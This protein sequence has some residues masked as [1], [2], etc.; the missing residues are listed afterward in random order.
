[1]GCA[2]E[3]EGAVTDFERN[4]AGGVTFSRVTVPRRAS[5]E[6]FARDGECLI[7]NA[8]RDEASAL[9]QTAAEIWALCDGVLSIGAIA[10]ALS[11]RYGVDEG[12]LVDEVAQALLTLRT[13]GLVEFPGDPAPDQP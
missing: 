7:Y 9:N 5:V 6:D 11:E 13:R 12:L 2:S 10:R 1:M 4:S 3:T 8:A